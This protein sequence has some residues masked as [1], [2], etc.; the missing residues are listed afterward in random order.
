MLRDTGGKDVTVGDEATVGHFA[1]ADELVLDDQVIVG[2][3]TLLVSSQVPGF[4]RGVTVQIEGEGEMTVRFS[5][6]EDDGALRR[7]VLRET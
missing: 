6:R 5:Q 1:V 2:V 7:V 3:P 4:T